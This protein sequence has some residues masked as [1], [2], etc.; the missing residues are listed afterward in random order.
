MMILMK[1]IKSSNK[2]KQRNNETNN[3]KVLITCTSNRV[4][5]ETHTAMMTTFATFSVLDNTHKNI[6][7]KLYQKHT[8]IYK[9]Y[10]HGSMFVMKQIIN[11]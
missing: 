8:H 1:Y 4:V 7:L 11:N 6:S 2:E 3:D 5:S 10:S 9:K